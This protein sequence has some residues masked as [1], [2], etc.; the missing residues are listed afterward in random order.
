MQPRCLPHSAAISFYFTDA[1]GESFG[2]G[3][4]TIAPNAQ[5]VAFMDEA[6]FNGSGQA[7]TFTF[8]SSL[9]VGAIALR[10]FVNERSEFLMTTLPV[11]PLAAVS[12]RSI[13]LP[14]FAAGGGWSTRIL[15]VNPSD[16]EIGGTVQT[17]TAAGAGFGATT[18]RIAPRSS[19]VVDV[20]ETGAEVR[21]GSVRIHPNVG[22]PA[23]IASTVF[24]SVNGGV[25]VTENGVAETESGHAFRLFVEAS[26]RFGEPDSTRTGIAIANSGTEAAILNLDLR[27]LNG[28]PTG[29]SASITIPAAGQVSVFLH[30]IP[31]FS[32]LATPFEGVLRISTASAAG[33]SM[34]GLR[35]RYNERGEFL[36]ATMPSVNEDAPAVNTEKVFPHIA[37]GDGYATQFILISRTPTSGHVRFVSQSGDPL[38]PTI[39]A[40]P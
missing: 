37:N 5:I 26:G 40:K 14:H 19:A 15:L 3:N 18:Y 7:R 38:T 23:P 4:T 21:V 2:A 10:G 34:I 13:V 39:P 16:T 22:D 20:S 29:S 17:L 9:P 36:I 28:V 27:D 1:N 32:N 31:G 30:E 8:S 6:P 11:A 33:I 24:S 12:T 35:G 25:T